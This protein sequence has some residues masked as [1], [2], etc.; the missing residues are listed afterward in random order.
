LG[1]LGEGYLMPE[2]NGRVTLA[3]LGERLTNLIQLVKEYHEE[4]CEERKEQDKRLRIVEQWMQSSTTLWKAH[5][6]DHAELIASYRQ[7]DLFNKIVAGI[8]AVIAAVV[9][10]VV[11]P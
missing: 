6:K 5:D 11:K 7:G 3:M 9:G 1:R 10:V 2:E 4:D 8:A